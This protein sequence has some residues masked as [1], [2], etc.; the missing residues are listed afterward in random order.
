M[1][2]LLTHM[3]SVAAVVLYGSVL[4]GAGSARAQGVGL[5]GGI[6]GLGERGSDTATVLGGLLEVLCA[7]AIVGTAVV[8]FP[9]VK[10]WGEGV[11]LG[12]AGLR[13]LEGGVILVGVVTLLA[14]VS[15]GRGPAT[16]P[17]AQALVAVHDWTFLVGPGLVCGVDT[18]LL[19]YLMVRSALVPRW[20]GVLGLVGGPLVF[21]SAVAVMFGG[22]AQMSA[23]AGLCALPTFAWELALALWLLAKGFRPSALAAAPPLD[24]PLVTGGRVLAGAR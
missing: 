12:Y 23:W 18:V 6:G 22:Y 5:L 4:G 3:T 16:A 19:A 24:G 10:H 13:G 2:F 21:A 11:A 7:M 14:T 8:L 9:V 15:L 17:A 20:I 1:L